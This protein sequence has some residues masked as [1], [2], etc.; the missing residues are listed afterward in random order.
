MF[1]EAQ[2]PAFEFLEF[3][4][5]D[6]TISEN[7]ITIPQPVCEYPST[8]HTSGVLVLANLTVYDSSVPSLSISIGT[9]LVQPTA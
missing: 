5:P 4:E 2:P 3:M 8:S 9:S 7:S 1:V 6:P